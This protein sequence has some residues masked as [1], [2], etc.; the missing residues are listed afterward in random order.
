MRC[1]ESGNTAMVRRRAW[2]IGLALLWIVPAFALAY[3]QDGD[4]TVSEEARA[5]VDQAMAHLSRY[6]SQTISRDRHV[7]YWEAL[8]WPD[9][10]LGCPIQGR[11]YAQQ[12]TPGYRIWITVGDVEYTYHTN[13]DGSVM[14]LC[15]NGSPDPST[16]GT[17]WWRLASELEAKPALRVAGWDAGDEAQPILD[18][19]R[20]F[21]ALFPNI[22]V[23][24]EPVVN[25][26]YEEAMKNLMAAGRAP[27]VFLIGPGLMSIFSPYGMLSPLDDYLGAVGLSRGDYVLALIDMFTYEGKTY[28]LPTTMDALGLVYLPGVFDRAG[29][30]Y[31]SAD[32]TWEDMM[33]AARTI[34]EKTGVYGMC[35]PPDATR[36][37]AAV[38]QAGGEITDAAFAE[39]RFNS[40][41]AVRALE[42]WYGMFADGYGVLPTAVN[43]SGCAEALGRETVAMSWEGVEVIVH[44]A[45]NYPTV[46]YAVAPLP[47]GPAGAANLAFGEGVS[48]NASTQ[49]PVAAA[50]LA[51]Y[52]ASPENQEALLHEEAMLPTLR[53]LLDDPWF[54]DHPDEAVIAQGASIGRPF[55][56]GHSFFFGLEHHQVL[57]QIDAALSAVFRGETGIQ[58]ALDAA[59]AGL[60]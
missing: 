13:A 49:H 8:T 29:V 40:P 54:D 23:V 36:W 7:F 28:A 17:N 60:N 26:D 35:V 22:E 55:Y 30:D 58:E 48:V 6:L 46:T 21:Q 38:Y 34:S 27:D 19:I 14:V 11:I 52:L 57:G 12:P 37:L 20:R 53:A 18:S 24:Y 39:A 10:S 25:E 9:A 4:G 33:T 44:M 47:A 51:M 59:V 32:W 45:E 56:F 1:S 31:P 41:E 43:M 50:L 2:V 42:F 15:I 16:M 5:R 3:A